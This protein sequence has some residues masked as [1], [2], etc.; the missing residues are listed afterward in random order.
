MTKSV[1]QDWITN[2]MSLR[3]QATVLSALRGCDGKPKNDPSKQLT[4]ALRLTM[5]VPADP[6]HMNDP[7]NTFMKGKLTQGAIDGVL[8]D[9][10]HYPLHWVAHFMQ[11][12]MLVGIHHP[13]LKTA[14]AWYDIYTSI[15]NRLHVGPE[16]AEHAKH[17]LRDG[18]RSEEEER[19]AR[20]RI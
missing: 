7:N 3:Q 9:L 17:R 8:D 20:A 19:G 12:A 16:P 2:R 13:D 15:C 11:A 5:L 18:K 10:D 4:R 14:N 1:V 6:D